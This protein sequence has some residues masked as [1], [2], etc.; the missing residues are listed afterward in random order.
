M[1][2]GEKIYCATCHNFGSSLTIIMNDGNQYFEKKIFFMSKNIHSAMCQILID[3]WQ[4]MTSTW[5]HGCNYNKVAMSCI[6]YTM[7]CKVATRA[8]CPL[9]LIQWVARVLYNPK[10]ELQGQLQNPLFFIVFE[11]VKP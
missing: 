2:C 4:S 5:H 7:S 8:T 10:I 3:G 11:D 1:T 9:A 6:I